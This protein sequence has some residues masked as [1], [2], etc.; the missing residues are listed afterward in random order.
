MVQAWRDTVLKTNSAKYL[1][2]KERAGGVA[3]IIGRR[4]R[5]D[6]SVAG[7]PKHLSSV[8]FV[9]IC[10]GQGLQRCSNWNPFENFEKR[11]SAADLC[12]FDHL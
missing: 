9:P 4:D 1:D 7:R 5:A 2:T 12:V 11:Q 10:L 6:L 3:G 8:L